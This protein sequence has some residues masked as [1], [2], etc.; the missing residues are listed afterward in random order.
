MKTSL[1]LELVATKMTQLGHAV[2]LSDNPGRYLCNYVYYSSLNQ[3]CKDDK[4]TSL[5]VHFP[6]LKIKSH[7]ENLKFVQDLLRVLSE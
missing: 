7:E 3:L 6:P 1:D 4:T 5:F 2:D